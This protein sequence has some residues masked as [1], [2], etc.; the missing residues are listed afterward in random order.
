MLIHQGLKQLSHFQAAFPIILL[1]KSNPLFTKTDP[2]E[3]AESLMREMAGMAV[4]I[5]E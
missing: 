2:Y 4:L 3:S 5:N 1:V